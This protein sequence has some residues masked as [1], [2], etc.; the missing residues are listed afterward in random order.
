M[1]KVNAE[2]LTDAAFSPVL[3]EKGI[4]SQLQRLALLRPPFG[5]REATRSGS[6]TR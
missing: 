1:K 5:N 3:D 6:E 2:K 4:C